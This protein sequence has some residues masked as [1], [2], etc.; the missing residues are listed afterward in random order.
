M[1][2]DAKKQ[3]DESWKETVEKEKTVK[4]SE[5]KQEKFQIP[6][7]DFKFFISTLSLQAFIALGELENP[8]S[9]KKEEDLN[10]A[11]FLIDTLDMLKEKTKGNLDEEEA[12][13]LEDVLYELK[14]KYVAKGG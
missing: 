10:Q 7:P 11:K 6:K 9:H 4:D 13:I 14:M 2:D 3:I 12:S 5:I 1:N 8:V